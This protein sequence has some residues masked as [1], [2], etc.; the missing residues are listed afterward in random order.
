MD[1]SLIKSADCSGADSRNYQAI[2]SSKFHITTY[3]NTIFMD[4]A[5]CFA[6]VHEKKI[7]C[8]RIPHLFN[9]KG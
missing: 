5:K 7:Q 9:K 4:I 3:S 2:C 6:V 8:E 1:R